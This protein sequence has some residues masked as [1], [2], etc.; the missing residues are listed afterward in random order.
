M[1]IGCDGGLGEDPLLLLV[2]SSEKGKNENE[3]LAQVAVVTGAWSAVQ[4]APWWA[5]SRE[6]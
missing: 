6:M 1:G 3:A 4:L 2:L 5:M